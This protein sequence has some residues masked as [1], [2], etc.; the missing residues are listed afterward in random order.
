MAFWFGPVQFKIRS[1]IEL[2][3]LVERPIFEFAQVIQVELH[4]VCD[5]LF[6]LQFTPLDS[7]YARHL[8]QPI[9]LVLITPAPSRP[10]TRAHEQPGA[11]CGDRKTGNQEQDLSEFNF[12]RR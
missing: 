12:R 7:H 6:R 4:E 5:S 11:C 3:F 8:I 1:Q 9:R 2:T 10:A